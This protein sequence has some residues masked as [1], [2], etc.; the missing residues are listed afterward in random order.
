MDGSTTSS[1]PPRL[2]HTFSHDVQRHSGIRK[3]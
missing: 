1:N 2:W 3:S